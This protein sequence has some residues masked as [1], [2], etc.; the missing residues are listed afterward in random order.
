M[1]PEIGHF[2]LIL[3]L[4][5]AAIQ[6]IVPFLGARC[7]KVAWMHIARSAAYTQ[8][9]FIAIAFFS[10]AYAFITND[11]SVA[12]VAEN[13]NV[14]LPLIYRFCA[15]W[16]AHAGSLLLWVFILGLW[17]TAVAWFSRHLPDDF[18]AYVLSVL[19]IVS[20][21]FLLYLLSTSNPFIRFL[22]NYPLNG[23]DLNPLLQDPGLVIHPPMLYMGYVGFSVAFAFAI[24]ALIERRFDVATWAQWVRPW[25][26]AAW[27]FLTWGITLGSWWSYRELGWGGWWAWD[28]VENA[29]FLPWLAGTALIHSLIVT[30]KRHAFIA[31]TILLSIITFSLSLIGTFLVRSGILISIHAFAMNPKCGIFM[32][33]FL[34]IILGGSLLLYVWR[35]ATVK[36]AIQIELWS[37]E[38][39]LLVNNILLTVAM[40]TVLIG[41][42]YP[43][44]IQVLGLGKLSVGPPYFN[45]VFI[46]LMIP[47]LI[48][49][50]W[51]PLFY[52][53]YRDPKSVIKRC[54]IGLMGAIIFS[55][56]LIILQAKQF[57]VSAA[58]GLSLAFWI[59]IVT[60]QEL[61]RVRFQHKR[62]MSLAHVGLAICV[63]GIVL[64][65]AYSVSRNVSM[66][67][68]SI[69]NVGPYEFKFLGMREIKGPNY[70][71]VEAGVKVF[72]LHHEITVLKPQLWTFPIQKITLSKV[73]I[74]VSIFRDIY[75]A[76]GEPL[77]QNAWSFRFYYKPFVRWIWGGG[78]LMFLGGLLA[79]IGKRKKKV[80][81]KE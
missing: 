72:H 32:L 74:D 39:M 7:H 1:I 46:P 36:S 73:A 40:L 30:E 69:V 29:S 13:S 66:T 12:Y 34:A 56:V 41:T 11:F 68:G 4:C 23:L 78:I 37:R 5:V 62:A 21:G 79:L 16:G 17:V 8:F 70:Q 53:K 71:G 51:G 54:W 22:P 58:L 55:V 65:S 18:I 47:I 42:L 80:N 76:L 3:A 38:S 45:T 28:P 52:W 31:W 10:L 19:G 67:M 14:F 64:S 24:A 61:Y 9:L 63:I 2:A 27:C 57:K 26:I 49:M 81:V 15:I 48:L 77:G 60:F 33:V 75:V 59:I 6:I 44:F 50:P 35:A 20:F 25:T 43:L